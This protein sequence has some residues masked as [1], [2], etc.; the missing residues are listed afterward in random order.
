MSTAPTPSPDTFHSMWAD[1]RGVAFRQDWLDAGGI[2]TRFLES[3]SPDDPL[4]VFLHGTGGHAEA[5]TRNLGAHGE[6]FHTLAIDMIGHGWTDKPSGSVEIPDYV[7]HLLRVLDALGVERAHISGESLGGWV[8][9]RL[10]IDHPDRLDKLVLNT[11]AGTKADPAVMA[12]IMELS[13]RAVEDPNWDFVR[14]RLEWLMHDPRHVNDDLVATRQAIYGQ[15][16][17]IEGMRATLCLQ[18][19]ETRARNLVHPEDL[20]RITAPTLVLWTTHDPTAGVDEAEKITAAIP[21][22]EMVVLDGCGHWPQFESA[23]EFNDVHLAFL[24]K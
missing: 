4:L 13:M 14:A 15:P 3:G 19:P 18:E 24:T 16:G 10:A 23:D 9:M 7:D 11:S 22:A 20:A 2:R 21:G 17:M 1:L 6:H 8:G 5:F 12:R